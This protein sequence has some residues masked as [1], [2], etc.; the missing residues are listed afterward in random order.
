M[1]TKIYKGF[2]IETDSFHEALQIVNAFRPVVEKKAE[3]VMEKFIENAKEAYKGESTNLID[4][5]IECFDLWNNMREK[6]IKQK[7]LK[8]PHID[9]DF[10]LT[11]VKLRPLG[12]SYQVAKPSGLI[13]M[14][15]V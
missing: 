1:S 7:G 13:F 4:I 2:K 6:I 12:R 5:K 14:L 3:D 10:T 11:T 9:T 8:A 15:Y